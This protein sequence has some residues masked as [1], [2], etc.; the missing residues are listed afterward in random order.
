MQKN[1]S[2][3]ESIL[4][5]KFLSTEKFK[6]NGMDHTLILCGKPSPPSGECKT[7]IYVLAKN[8]IN[9]E[10][11]EIKISLKLDNYEFLEN[12]ISETTAKIIFGKKDYRTIIIAAATSL[13]DKFLKQVKIKKSG[14]C[15]LRIPLGWKIELF[16]Q[17]SR[18]L[19]TSLE[20]GISLFNKTK[21][22]SLFFKY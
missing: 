16:N 17:T 12:K 7:D 1:F 8:L 5:K 14:S 19:K 11:I 22:S 21:I 2:L 15:I 10:N 3:A 18:R 9:K 4:R 13:K 20:L 6:F